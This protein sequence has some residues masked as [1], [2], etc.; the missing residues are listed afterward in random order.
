M[1]LCSQERVRVVIQMCRVHWHRDSTLARDFSTALCPSERAP[2]NA[3]QH[4]LSPTNADTFCEDFRL[5]NFRFAGGTGCATETPRDINREPG[6][7]RESRRRQHGFEVVTAEGANTSD[8]ITSAETTPKLPSYLEAIS[9]ASKEKGVSATSV[10]AG[11]WTEGRI[12][13]EE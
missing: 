2:T 10:L 6:E 8:Q 5:T 7:T 13:N 12:M 4:R 9:A 3:D 11:R 1:G